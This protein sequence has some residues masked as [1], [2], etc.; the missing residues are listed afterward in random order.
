M[1]GAGTTKYENTGAKIIMVLFFFCILN[2]DSCI[3]KYKTNNIFCLILS[4]K[5]IRIRLAEN[6]FAAYGIGRGK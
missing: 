3:L 2:S 6:N 1:P 4:I 5:M